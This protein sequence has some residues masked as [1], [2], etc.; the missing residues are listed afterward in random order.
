MA[1]KEAENRFR[2]YLLSYCC[3]SPFHLEFQKRLNSRDRLLAPLLS[4][5]IDYSTPEGRLQLTILAAFAAYFSDMLAK[6]TS[7]GKGERAAQGLPNG[8]IPFGYCWTSPKSPP[9][10]DPAEFPGLR[11]IGEL[12]MQ[13]KTAEYIADAVNAAGYRTGSK[14]FGVRLFTKDTVTAMLRNEF[15][16]AYAPGDDRGIVKYHDKRFR[17]LHLAAFTFEE[18][19]CIRTMTQSLFH[20]SARTERVKSVYE[21][22][23]YLVCL[24]CGLPLRCDTGNTPE[25]HRA[26]YRDAAKARRLP[27]PVG[28]NLMVRVDTVH[29]QFGSLL[30]RLIL[31]EDWRER[32]RRE[33][34]TK[35]SASPG[36]PA[37]IEREKER[38]TLKKARTLKQHREGYL[39]DETFEG[40]MAA[41][42]LAFKKYETP[43][44]NGISIE[45]LI[46]TGKRLPGMAALW[47]L[48]TPEERRE[49]VTLMLEPRGLL[50]NTKGKMIMALKPRPAFLSLFLLLNGVVESPETP[51]LL[52]I[53]THAD[54]ERTGG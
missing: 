38:L 11:M 34:M 45:E 49:M 20:A 1:R 17:G 14:R 32:L 2:N 43:E 48:A 21:F 22:A 26:Y 25:N 8:D 51:G 9:E 37:T 35:S 5:H 31:P 46:E 4:E 47:D 50:Y 28:G 52:I 39:D 44:V 23:S 42:T 12:R 16:A 27:C 53:N 3:G 54:G 18:W 24:H 29:E 33:I 13:G 6:H 36:T 10:H 41:I 15:Y 30:K 19:Q 40:E 7:K